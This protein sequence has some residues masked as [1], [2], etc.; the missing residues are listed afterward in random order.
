MP[1]GRPPHATHLEIQIKFHAMVIGLF[2]RK[3]IQ[4]LWGLMQMVTHYIKFEWLLK[5][6]EL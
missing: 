1:I 5:R 4:T 3:V 2:M 6:T